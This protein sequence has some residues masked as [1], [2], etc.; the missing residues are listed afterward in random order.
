MSGGGGGS[1]AA[2]SPALS[3]RGA[4]IAGAAPGLLDEGF[5]LYLA[6]PFDRER[7]PEVRGAA[8]A[9]RA[10]SSPA[11]LNGFVSSRAC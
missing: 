1:P 8:A 5:A 7:N 2:P 9:P 10:G 4:R 3:G 11:P 6:D